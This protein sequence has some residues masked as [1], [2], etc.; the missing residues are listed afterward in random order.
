MQAGDLYKAYLRWCEINQ[1]K[2]ASNR[3]FGDRLNDLG[4]QKTRSNFYYYVDIRLRDDLAGTTTDGPPKRHK[5]D[6]GY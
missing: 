1:L 4:F 2:A 3:S 6:P 5:D